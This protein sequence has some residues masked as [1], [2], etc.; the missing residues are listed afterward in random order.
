MSDAGQLQRVRGIRLEDVGRTAVY[1]AS[2][3]ST[4][5]TG[6]ELHIDGGL[7]AGTAAQITDA[8]A[9]AA[10]AKSMLAHKTAAMAAVGDIPA[11]PPNFCTGCPERPVFSAIK[12]MQR[13]LGPTHISADIGCH[14]FATFAPFSLGN[15]IL[16][17]GMSLASA[18]AASQN[19]V[20]SVISCP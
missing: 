2:D 8:D 13:E 19:V 3:E 20:S 9:I 7:L 12:L 5:V 17:Y 18:A 6:T 4:Y 11:R 1:L 14:S 10:R 16:G 15:S